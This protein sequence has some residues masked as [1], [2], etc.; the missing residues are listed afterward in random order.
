[1]EHIIAVALDHNNAIGRA[2][3]L[4]WSLPDDLKRFKSLTMGQTVL[5]GR[6][7]AQSL[8]RALPGRRNLVLTSDPVPPFAQME[9]VASIAAAC[10]TAAAAGASQLWS[11][12]GGQV[13]AAMMPIADVLEVTHV[14]TRIAEA[15][16]FFPPIDPL[17]WVAVWREHH[18]ADSRHSVAFEYV[19]YRRR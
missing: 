16:V 9:T 17:R 2:N 12:G 1:M 4:P 11:I 5:M 15:D 7:T 6:K 8:R 18:A 14:Q 3:R 13:Y 10:A 19:R